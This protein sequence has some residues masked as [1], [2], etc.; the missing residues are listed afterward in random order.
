MNETPLVQTDICSNTNQS[1]HIWI[2]VAGQIWPAGWTL[3]IPSLFLF[4]SLVTNV[5]VEPSLME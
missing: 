4:F 3:S 5:C 2:V 1:K